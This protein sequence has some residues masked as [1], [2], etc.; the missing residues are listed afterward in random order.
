[1]RG[2]K[3]GLSVNLE[4]A[5]LRR[6]PRRCAL[7]TSDTNGVSTPVHKIFTVELE[8]DI[9]KGEERRG[10]CTRALSRR[11]RPL[12]QLARAVL[13]ALCFLLTF[14]VCARQAL[15]PSCRAT[16]PTHQRTFS[17]TDASQRSSPPRLSLTRATSAV[18]RSLS[19]IFLCRGAGT[20]GDVRSKLVR[21]FAHAYARCDWRGFLI[22]AE[23]FPL[24]IRSITPIAA[25]ATAIA[26][27]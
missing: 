4:N 22:V 12:C 8:S 25:I 24:I 19:L 11:R 7:Y 13:A 26:Q 18:Q 1:M 16:T 20:V 2:L 14:L 5:A 23:R 3:V 10:A 15:P 6:M 17:L 21:S 9:L 27:R